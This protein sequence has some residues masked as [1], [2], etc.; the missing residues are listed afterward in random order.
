M[1]AENLGEVRKM[2]AGRVCIILKATREDLDITQEKLAGTLGWTR[3]MVANLE[4]GRRTLTF[5]DFVVIAR[6]F[7]IE[8]ERLPRRT[9][10]W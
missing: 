10:Q 7:N 9:L 4:C 8:P 1:C 2:L 6:A 3:S 5:A